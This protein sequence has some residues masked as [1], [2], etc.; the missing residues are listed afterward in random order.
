MLG[1]ERLL[2]IGGQQPGGKADLCPETNSEAVLQAEHILRAPFSTWVG[3]LSSCR[4]AQ[5]YC[6]IYS[7]RKNQNPALLLD[8]C[9]SATPPLFLHSLPS[10]SSSCLNLSFRSQGVRMLNEVYF[11]QTRNGGQK[12]FVPGRT[13]QS[14]SVSSVVCHLQMVTVFIPPLNLDSFSFSC[15][16]AVA[17]TLLNKSCKSGHCFLFLILMEM[18]SAFHCWVWC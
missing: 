17:G 2:Y 5:R 9:S 11:L 15:L 6:Y 12:R 4:K 10:V 18:C 3:G 16:I 7:L 1:K 14:C 13:W 8:C